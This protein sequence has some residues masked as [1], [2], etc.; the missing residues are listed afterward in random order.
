[1]KFIISIF[2]F[3][4]TFSS[5][6]TFT[7]STSLKKSNLKKLKKTL[8]IFRSPAKGA[9][10]IKDYKTDLSNWLGVYGKKN[11]IVL[12]SEDKEYTEYTTMTKFYQLSNDNDFMKFKTMG[13][14][15]HFTNMNKEGLKKLLL[16]NSAD[17][18]L[19]YEIDCIF[20]SELM[21]IDFSSLITILDSNLNIVYLDHQKDYFRDIAIDPGDKD[22]IKKQTM[23][24]VNRRLLDKLEDLKLVKK[25]LK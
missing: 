24:L 15:T 17:S 6:S 9:I 21:F 3:L 19:I 5:C 4:I 23:N 18:I 8:V 10:S 7:V 11:N 12:S 13:T 16:T 20:S 22:K 25:G 2:L 1:M 14:I